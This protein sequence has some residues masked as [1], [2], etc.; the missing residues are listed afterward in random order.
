[1]DKM[2]KRSKKE[3]EKRRKALKSKDIS[4]RGENYQWKVLEKT[5]PW[6]VVSVDRG[7]SIIVDIPEGL[8]TTVFLPKEFHVVY[9]TMSEYTADHIADL[10]NKYLKKNAIK[11]PYM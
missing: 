1:M 6:K 7:W 5:L 9:G 8:R 3:R 4:F 2:I 10:H 11:C